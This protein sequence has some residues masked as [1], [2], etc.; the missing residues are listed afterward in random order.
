MQNGNLAHSVVTQCCVCRRY[1]VNGE[2]VTVAP[3]ADCVSH[4]YCIDCATEI[5]V[6]Y[7]LRKEVVE[8][9]VEAA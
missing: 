1:K 8:E 9:K 7:N 4:T 6:A 3:D 2:W 5:Y